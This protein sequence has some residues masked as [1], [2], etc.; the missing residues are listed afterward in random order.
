MATFYSLFL[1]DLKIAIYWLLFT[2]QYIYIYIYMY[3]CYVVAC[4]Y[5][6]MCVCMCMYVC[7]CE[8]IID[9]YHCF[10]INPVCVWTSEMS[11]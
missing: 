3:I 4:V 10:F 11:T 2:L 8:L 5:V 9:V 1:V 7:V 6:Y